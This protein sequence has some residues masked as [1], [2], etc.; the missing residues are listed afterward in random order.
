MR[1]IYRLREGSL[2]VHS[3]SKS[4][5]AI[6]QCFVRTLNNNNNNNKYNVF[7]II[8][9][10][11]TAGKCLMRIS[12]SRFHLYESTFT[13]LFLLHILC[14]LFFRFW[15]MEYEKKRKMKKM[16]RKEKTQCRSN[17]RKIAYS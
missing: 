12:H 6:R 13:R 7:N 2:E 8:M 11:T 14:V 17:P 10:R 1:V 4:G 16:K 5:M 9:S 3:R 15:S